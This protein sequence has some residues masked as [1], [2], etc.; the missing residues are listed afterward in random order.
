[1]RTIQGVFV[2]P[3]ERVARLVKVGKDIREI[4]SLLKVSMMEIFNP[5]RRHHGPDVEIWLDE[6]GTLREKPGWWFG[7]WN[8]LLA[9]RCFICRPGLKS[10]PKSEQLDLVRWRRPGMKESIAQIHHLNRARSI[11]D[12]GDLK[13]WAEDIRQSDTLTDMLAL[14]TEPAELLL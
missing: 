14:A 1:M 5:S 10:L 3:F 9:G 6:M 11:T 12:S 7:G 13:A 4:E 8:Q 2:D